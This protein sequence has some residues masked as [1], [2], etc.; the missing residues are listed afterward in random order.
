M[1]RPHTFTAA[2]CLT[3]WV[4]FGLGLDALCSEILTPGDARYQLKTP[5]YC[6]YDGTKLDWGTFD[7][8]NNMRQLVSQVRQMYF[9]AGSFTYFG[10]LDANGKIYQISN[11]NNIP[12]C[13]ILQ[14]NVGYSPPRLTV[15]GDGR[16]VISTS[17]AYVSDEKLFVDGNARIKDVLKLDPRSSAPANPTAGWI[18]FD[19]T[20]A[21]MRCYDG[22]AWQNL[23]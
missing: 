10:H 1:K 5:G 8:W 16:L 4:F 12:S 9:E 23:W 20:L 18:Y 17:P 21:K 11:C 3:A 7:T 15:Y 13:I 6:Q 2:L 19:S 22:S 14:T